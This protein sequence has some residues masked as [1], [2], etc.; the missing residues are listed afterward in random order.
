MESWIGF[1]DCVRTGADSELI[2]RIRAVFGSSSVFGIHKPLS[3]GAHRSGSLMTSK[4]TGMDTGAIRKDRLDYWEA[5]SDWHIKQTAVGRRPYNALF[6][7]YRE[8]W[9]PENLVI[10]ESDI[11]VCKYMVNTMVANRPKS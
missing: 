4:E 8:Y 7:T 5:W 9:I 3:L 10:S 1:W 6:N 11:E 2:A